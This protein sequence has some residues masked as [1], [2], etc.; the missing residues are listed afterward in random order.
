MWEEGKDWKEVSCRGNMY[1]MRSK[2]SS[3][4]IQDENE[5]NILSDYTLINVGGISGVL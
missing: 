5:N 1:N 4:G 2:F 3:K